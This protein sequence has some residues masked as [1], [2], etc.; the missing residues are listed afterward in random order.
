MD[1]AQ[2]WD[3]RLRI[4]LTNLEAVTE[5]NKKGES[6]WVCVAHL[7]QLRFAW[8]NHQKKKRKTE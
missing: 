6:H 4:W 3:T 2:E 7:L 1:A 5:H 8:V